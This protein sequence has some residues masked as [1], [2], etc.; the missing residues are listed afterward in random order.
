M[1]VTMKRDDEVGALHGHYR[2]EVDF[3]YTGTCHAGLIDEHRKKIRLREIISPHPV[4]KES[5]I[6][7]SLFLPFDSRSALSAENDQALRRRKRLGGG[8]P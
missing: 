3:R 2:I 4:C 7:R 6:I 8:I 1:S 5:F